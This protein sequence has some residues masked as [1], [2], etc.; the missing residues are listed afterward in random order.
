[1]KRLEVPLSNVK[2]DEEAP[3]K[4]LDVVVMVEGT[5]SLLEVADVCNGV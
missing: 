2:S 1:M 5:D 3:N 4:P